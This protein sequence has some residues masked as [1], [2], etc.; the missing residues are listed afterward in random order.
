[1]FNVFVVDRAVWM[2]WGWHILELAWRNC[3][4]ESGGLLSCFFVGMGYDC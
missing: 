3:A 2:A 4:I 1:M